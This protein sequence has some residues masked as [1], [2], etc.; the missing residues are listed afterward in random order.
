MLLEKAG[1]GN[2]KNIKTRLKMV[3]Y[4]QEQEFLALQEK[5]SLDEVIDWIANNLAPED[6]FAVFILE[7]WALDN[8]FTKEEN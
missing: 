7:D 4:Q 3:K 1:W 2:F 6:V 5:L 8:G